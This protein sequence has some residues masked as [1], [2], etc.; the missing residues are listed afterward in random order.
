MK[1]HEIKEVFGHNCALP[2]RFAALPE[3]FAVWPQRDKNGT[4]NGFWERSIALDKRSTEYHA[5]S[6]G[7]PVVSQKATLPERCARIVRKACR[8]EPCAGVFRAQKCRRSASVFAARV[9]GKSVPHGH[10]FWQ[11]PRVMPALCDI[12]GKLENAC[13]PLYGRGLEGCK[14]S[15]RL[16]LMCGKP[17]WQS[18]QTIMAKHNNFVC[19]YARA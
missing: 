11:R 15:R 10:A 6:I 12:I 9:C 5:S 7:R 4:W 13:E 1:V 18:R 14:L 8:E 2:E 19:Q 17:L 16:G 3:R